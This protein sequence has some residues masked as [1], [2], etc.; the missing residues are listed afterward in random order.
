[1]T[2]YQR[3]IGGL[4]ML[5][6][7]CALM[8]IG[9]AN[10]IASPPPVAVTLPASTRTVTHH[11]IVVVRKV[12]KGRVVRLPSGVRVVRV[13]RFVVH[14]VGCHRVPDHPCVRRVVVPAQTVRLRKATIHSAVATAIAVPVTVTVYV[15]TTVYQTVTEPAVTVTQTDTTTDTQIVTITVSVPA[16]GTT[17]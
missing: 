8:G 14:T 4:I 15:P 2:P 1:M 3:R 17:P 16:E 10:D 9:A 5:A 13:P 12:V 7:G 6:I 11:R